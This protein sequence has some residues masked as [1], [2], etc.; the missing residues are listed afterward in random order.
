[1]K[2][3]KKQLMMYGL[4]AIIFCAVFVAST[5]IK[6]GVGENV[7]GWIWGG[8]NDGNIT[9]QGVISSGVGWISMNNT[10][11]AGAVSYGVNIPFTD[12]NLSGSAYSENLGYIAFDNSNGYLNGCPIPDATH[13]CNAYREG[14]SIKG[15][16]RF[17]EISKASVIGN[18]GGW[19]GWIRLNGPSYGVTIGNDG[20]LSGNAWSDELGVISFSGPGYGASMP[21][22][23]TVALV[24]NPLTINL[25][26]G[27]LPQNVTLTWTVTGAT[28]CT[29]SANG[30]VW[31]GTIN[32]SGNETVSQSA[33]TVEYIL[34]CTGIANP[35]RV[36]VTTGCGKKECSGAT[37]GSTFMVTGT[38]T[39]DSCTA[40]STCSLD[41]DCAARG[42][43]GW[44]E[45]A[46]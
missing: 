37:C 3:T 6:A 31:S 44:S 4:V 7:T 17:V 24:V 8:S 39:V 19:L 41:A 33:A 36:N 20:K 9:G 21:L 25:D 34:T 22:P 13:S 43:T 14:N 12:G 15:W 27:L 32:A 40:A 16:A 11:M 26:S 18:S 30:G 35:V 28:T 45:V 1:M 29:K 42:I 5:A 46:P 38:S 10:N 2:K 23:P